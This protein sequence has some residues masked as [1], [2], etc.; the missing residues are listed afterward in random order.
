MV[1]AADLDSKPYRLR[2]CRVDLPATSSSSPATSSFSPATG[3]S[4]K[5]VEVITIEMALD[6]AQAQAATHPQAS[7]YVGDLSTEVRSLA[8]LPDPAGDRGDAVREVLRGGS[9]A[10]HQGVQGHDHQVG[11]GLSRGAHHR[12]GERK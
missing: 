6:Q 4:P 5:A 12:G 3:S 1:P 7:L 10:L 8:D 9:R 2:R 11:L